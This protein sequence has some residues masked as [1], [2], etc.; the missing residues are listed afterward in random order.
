[1]RRMKASGSQ[2]V[3]MIENIR[4]LSTLSRREDTMRTTKH[5]HV[6][7]NTVFSR[8]KTHKNMVNW[9]RRLFGN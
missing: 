6:A 5:E 1:M 4:F 2:S 9:K 3:I 8:L 7:E